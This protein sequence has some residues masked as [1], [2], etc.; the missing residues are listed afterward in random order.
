MCCILTIIKY[1]TIFIIY[2]KCLIMINLWKKLFGKKGK[3]KT[4]HELFLSFMQ[5]TKERMNSQ[6]DKAMME[7]L[8]KIYNYAIKEEKKEVSKRN[9][10]AVFVSNDLDIAQQKERE[11]EAKRNELPHPVELK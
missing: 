10:V 3:K 4:E 1:L 11:E 7:Y 6:T 5:K 2:A 8:E 9:R